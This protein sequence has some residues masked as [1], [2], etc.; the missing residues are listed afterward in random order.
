M[1]RPSDPSNA[2]KSASMSRIAMREK[3]LRVKGFDRVT[4]DDGITKFKT[5]GPNTGKGPAI[6]STVSGSQ[7]QATLNHMVSLKSK[8]LPS[9][10][11]DASWLLNNAQADLTYGRLAA[12]AM[13]TNSVNASVVNRT[14]TQGAANQVIN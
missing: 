3:R 12:L 11:T 4:G 7:G 14:K 13:Q 6:R 8:N 10:C 1:A 5:S 2:A 9:V